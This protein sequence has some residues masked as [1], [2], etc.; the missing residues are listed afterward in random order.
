MTTSWHA[1]DGLLGAYAEGRL[2]AARA[3]SVEQHLTDC[4]VCRSAIAPHADATLL[5]RVWADTV[6]VLD[7]PR[8]TIFER[9]LTGLGLSAESARLAIGSAAA[10]R[11]WILGCVLVATFAVAARD[12]EGRTA[13]WFLT[14]APLVPLTGIAVAYGPGSF[15]MHDVAAAAPYPRLRLILLRCLPVLPVTTVLLLF[16]GLVLPRTEV[17]A[18][19]LLPGLALATISLVAERFIG[20]APSVTALSL[21]WIGFVVSARIATGSALTA[22]SPAV[23]LLSLLIVI[24]VAAVAV[25]GSHWTRRVS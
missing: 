3:A 11:A 8:A 21:I 13:M 9:A 1:D 19:W 4:A 20:A 24:A 5:D 10:R 18:L 7:R 2:D 12:V 23:Q 16:G 17:A 14:V 6:D 25:L 22:F 15:P